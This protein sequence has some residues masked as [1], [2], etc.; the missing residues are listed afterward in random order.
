MGVVNGDRALANSTTI[1]NGN[2]T[3]PVIAIEQ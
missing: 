2:T 3:R 1:K